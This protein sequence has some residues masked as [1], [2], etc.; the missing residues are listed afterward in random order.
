[1]KKFLLN[2]KHLFIQAFFLFY[3]PWFVI[4][5]KFVSKYHVIHVPLDDTIPFC[6]YFIMPYIIWFL[7]V[8]FTIL[9]TS[10]HDHEKYYYGSLYL[11]IG[12]T[13][14]LI[15]STIYPTGHLLRVANFSRD[16]T[17]ISLVKFL[18]K[19]DTPTN[20]LPSIHVYNSAACLVILCKDKY[21]KQN[22]LLIIVA[23]LLTISIIL[24][25]VFL[26]QHSIADV[27]SGILLSY[28]F[29]IMFY[30]RRLVKLVNFLMNKLG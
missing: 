30:V 14:F 22:R 25:T 29:Y 1:M 8:A 5:E 2:N 27:I 12:M 26:K 18:Y 6:E 23:F 28:L 20:I 16:N 19:I 3:L 24:S 10:T 7:Y 11:F 17:C 4:L 13:L 21:F 9:F 15:I